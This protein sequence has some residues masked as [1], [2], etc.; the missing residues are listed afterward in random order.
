MKR[1]R[2]IFYPI[3]L[4]ISA[5]NFYSC[6][7]KGSDNDSAYDLTYGDSVLYLRPSLGDYIV[8]PNTQRT[9]EYSGF[10]EGIEIDDKT[11]AI[12]ISKSETGLRYRITHTAPDGTIST[13][14]VVLSGITYF[15]QFYHLSQN[16]TIAFP[17]YNA[18]ASSPLPLTGSVFDDG[19]GAGATGCEVK[20]VNG[21]IN[22]AQTVRNGLFGSSPV[23]DARRDIEILYRLNDGSGKTVNKLKVRLYY[24]TSM[25]AV[26]PDLLETLAERQNGGVFLKGAGILN[27][28]QA[29]KPRPPCVIIIAN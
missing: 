19:G 23:N 9:G 3:I 27:T 4:F 5:L 21:Q 1:S 14:K 13:T 15:D 2:R 6:T 20:T 17:V 28:E 10:P 11:G 7:K 16:D 26:A 18:T 29:A 22:L 12:N 8:Y 24:Y 25:A